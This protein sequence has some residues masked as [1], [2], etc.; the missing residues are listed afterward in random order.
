[1]NKLV[2]REG[3]AWSCGLVALAL[4]L[5]GQARTAQ[6]QPSGVSGPIRVP[7]WR[8]DGPVMPSAIKQM[9]VWDPDGAGPESAMLLGVEFNSFRVVAIRNGRYLP[10]SWPLQTPLGNRGRVE[11]SGGARVSA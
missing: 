5:V 2:K 10:V 1:M 3:R 9:T 11:V 7:N 6:A 8:A 4:V